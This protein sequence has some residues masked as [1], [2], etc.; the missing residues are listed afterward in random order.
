MKVYATIT[1]LDDEHRVA[2]GYASTE[3]L[4]CQGEIVKREALEA[5]LPDYLKFAN[6]REMHSHSAVGVA[7]GAEMDDKGL[8]LSAHIVDPLAWKKVKAGVYKGFSI[9]GRVTSRDE[10]NPHII[11]GLDLNEISLVDRPANPEATIDAW[12]VCGVLAKE[13]RR[14]SEGDQANL[15]AAHDAI[16]A[17]GARCPASEHGLPVDLVTQARANGDL[18]KLR[19]EH[20]DL[21]KQVADLTQELTALRA[22]PQ[23]GKGV[24]RAVGKGEDV[25]PPATGPNPPSQTERWFGFR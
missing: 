4:D 16:V 21:Q 11:T 23:P 19:R 15:N 10:E 7:H 1:K 20:D 24:L 17:A 12:K 18:A 14:N 2:M 25:T 22:K 13:G 9:G 8:Y 3:A 6:I 5:A